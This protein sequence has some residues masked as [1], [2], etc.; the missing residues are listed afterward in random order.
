M[1]GA[2]PIRICR[3]LVVVLHAVLALGSS[4]SAQ[5]DTTPL[6]AWDQPTDWEALDGSE[7]AVP[8]EI[9]VGL[10]SEA[11]RA[12]IDAGLAR[13]GMEILGEIP[14]LRALRLRVGD[15]RS[16]QEACSVARSMP[17]VAYAELNGTGGV[18]GA[19]DGAPPSDTW[20]AQQWH[21][22]NTGQSG[23]K[24]GADIEALSAWEF[25][26]EAP[27]IVVAV[28][29]TGILYDHPEFTGSVLQ[30]YDCV[31]EDD[32]AT[33]TNPHG[34]FVA[35]LLGAHADNGFGVAGVAPACRILPVRVLAGPFGGTFNLAQGIDYAVSQAA[36]ILSMSLVNYPPAEI[37]KSA[38]KQAADAG[39]LMLAS[40][41]NSGPGT[42]DSSYP[43]ASP[44]V[45]S[46]GAT[47]RFDNRA[48]FSAT[49]TVLDFVA[50]GA[51]V[52]TVAESQDDDFEHFT[53]T[54][55]A[56][57][58]ASGIAALLKSYNASL[59]QQQVYELLR[60]GAED[61]VGHSY[62]D[63][64]GWDPYHGHGRL[65]A[66]RSLQALCS[67]TAG[68]AFTVSPPALAFGVEGSFVFRLAAGSANALQPYLMLGTLAGT[69]SGFVLGQTSWPLDLDPYTRLLLSGSSP[70]ASGVG[71]LDADGKAIA[72]LTVPAAARE[73]FA[74]AT[75]HHAAAIYDAALARPYEGVPLL[76]AGPVASGIHGLPQQLF[77]ETFEAGAPGWTIDN[78]VNGQW[79][80]APAG[81]CGSASQRAAY[82]SGEPGCSFGNSTSGL[83]TSP[84]FLM[85]GLPPYRIRVTSVVV[86]PGDA[87]NSVRLRLVD[88]SFETTLAT[89][90][91]LAADFGEPVPGTTSTYELIVPESSKYD[92]RFV[93]L[94]AR[95]T[96]PSTGSGQG[97]SLDDVAVWNA[98]QE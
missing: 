21:L 44:F 50:P 15:S 3:A 63:T 58:I 84:S 98:G 35:G 61:Q 26:S 22:A 24:A 60:A 42:A 59:T 2:N 86:V 67:C 82:N 47:N 14:R 87:K 65:N 1:L 43:A 55:A 95:F 52:V 53:G 90:E 38:L 8:G 81:E 6:A 80:I 70:M 32:D 66:F 18:A 40:A 93:H 49:G 51:N 30:G 17:G 94:E 62:E 74:G 7:K 77:L 20:F 92:G 78:G 31:D 28:L 73:T 76:L 29:D 48:S 37:L 72:T 16:L 34:V 64:P 88:E 10:T 75:F 27:Q 41:G 39:I 36:D 19:A 89:Q 79:H 11:N 57:P 69:R 68:D 9:I 5:R 91:W 83:L 46:I 4:A 71:V 85:S 33:L 56:A 54:S 96:A 25:V 23:G 13:E 45:M 12:E 97:W